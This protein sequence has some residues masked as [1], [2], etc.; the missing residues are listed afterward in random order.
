M[1]GVKC[2]AGR[3]RE[4]NNRLK[5]T[6][7]NAFVV[8]LAVL[9]PPA[10]IVAAF[11]SA[12][13]GKAKLA[14]TAL[15]LG[16]MALYVAL[17]PSADYSVNGYVR[18]VNLNEDAK[19]YGPVLPE[20]I[21]TDVRLYGAPDVQSVLAQDDSEEVSVKYYYAATDAD[22]YHEYE[23]KFAYASSQKLTLREASIL[24]YEPCGLCKPPV[25]T[26]GA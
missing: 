3:R 22:C 1:K 15:A 13:S 26:S 5:K 24:G 25:Y 6:M 10:G 2:L 18:L 17:L 20:N 11:R 7:A 12:F 23:C 8:M 4:R 19:I 14:L 16:C 9:C 21:V